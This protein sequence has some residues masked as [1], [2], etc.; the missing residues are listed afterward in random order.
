M[1]VLGIIF[2]I[3]SEEMAR[4]QKKNTKQV[5]RNKSKESKAHAMSKKELARTNPKRE[6]S[7]NEIMFFRLGIS[8][9][10]LTLVVLAA[11]LL[12][13]YFT[14]EAE[15]GPYEEYLHIGQTELQIITQDNNDGTFGDFP[16]FAGKEGYEDLRSFLNEHDVIYIYFYSSNEMNEEIKAEIMNLENIENLPIL[17]IDLDSAENETIFENTA[18]SHLNI[19]SEAT[20]MLLVFDLFPESE[21]FVLHTRVDDIIAELGKL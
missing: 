15:V 13:R 11:V 18:L 16:F 3:G 19:D 4:V 12:V 17:F 20:D 10:A 9:I 8:A 2:M 1:D 14:T 21:F 5:T 7:R 6:P